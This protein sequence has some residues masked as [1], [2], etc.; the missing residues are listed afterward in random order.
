MQRIVDID[1]A[2]H[3]RLAVARE[4]LKCVGGKKRVSG[5]VVC[6]VFIMILVACVAL[7]WTTMY[8]SQFLKHMR[9]IF[10]SIVLFLHICCS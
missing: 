3:T 8:T 9:S 4:R 6:L 2:V 7:I 1:L 10:I 5:K